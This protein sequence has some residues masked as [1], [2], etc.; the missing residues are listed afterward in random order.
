MCAKWTGG[1]KGL[2]VERDAIEGEVMR[3]ANGVCSSLGVCVGALALI[4]ATHPARV[5]C[6]PRRNGLCVARAGGVLAAV[7]TLQTGASAVARDGQHSL[8]A[9]AHC[10]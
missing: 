6:L 1:R 8:T 7:Q 3:I 4:P 10:S 2:V 9:Y 5:Q